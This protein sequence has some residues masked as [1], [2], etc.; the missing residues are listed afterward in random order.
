[1]IGRH[2]IGLNDCRRAPTLGNGLGSAKPVES[3]LRRDFPVKTGSFTM[4][5]SVD[6]MIDCVVTMIGLD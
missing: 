1:V 5:R 4:M 3:F 2:R 6:Q